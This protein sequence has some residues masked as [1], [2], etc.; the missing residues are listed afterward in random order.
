ML[1]SDG[2]FHGARASLHLKRRAGA[3][4]PARPPRSTLLRP[5]SRGGAGGEQDLILV[6]QVPSAAA[7]LRVFGRLA[8][9]A[10]PAGPWV[11]IDGYH[12][13]MA[14]ENPFCKPC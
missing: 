6:S 4:H 1:T 12:A 10:D 3:G 8:A 5:L 14:L 7:D 2:E 11:V 9:L 13:F